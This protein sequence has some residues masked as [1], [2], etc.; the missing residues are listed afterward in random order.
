VFS[1]VIRLG[2]HTAK[3]LLDSPI[4]IDSGLD[5]RR[6]LATFCKCRSIGARRLFYGHRIGW[7]DKKFDGIDIA[8]T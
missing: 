4:V 5:R 2:H 7:L 1:F 8:L 6:A 3:P